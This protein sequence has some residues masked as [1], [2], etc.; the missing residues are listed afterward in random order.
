MNIFHNLYDIQWHLPP[1]KELLGLFSAYGTLSR[2][3][4]HLLCNFS[5]LMS[6]W[7]S[8]IL[9]LS[10]IFTCKCGSN[11]LFNSL[12]LGTKIGKKRL[13]LF[14]FQSV[15]TCRCSLIYCGHLVISFRNRVIP[16]VRHKWE[17]IFSKFLHLLFYRT[18]ID[19]I[20]ISTA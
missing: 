5:S 3:Q 1:F 13:P 18:G 7:K 10:S 16:K 20:L 6:F 15:L 12:Y 2:F 11:I 9:S 19:R 8:L 14:K 17:T 4:I